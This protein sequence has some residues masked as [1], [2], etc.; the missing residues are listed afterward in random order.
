[1]SKKTGFAVFGGIGGFCLLLGMLLLVMAVG[2]LRQQQRYQAGR[3]TILSKHL[4]ASYSSQKNGGSP[5]Y[6]PSFEFTVMTADGRHYHASG[7]DGSNTSTSGLQSQQ[8]IIDSY[9]IGQSYPCWYDPANPSQAVL[10]HH[11]NWFL[12][13][14]SAVLLLVGGMLGT[15]GLLI[16][17]G[18]VTLTGNAQGDSR[19][20]ER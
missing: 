20:V 18:R 7:Y 12:F 13:V 14:A 1:M 8:A 4:L 10:V 15:G 2:A 16:R 9:A 11:P 17:L 5:M 6:E 19:G 3:C